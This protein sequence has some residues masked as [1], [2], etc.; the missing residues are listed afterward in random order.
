MHDTDNEREREYTNTK[1]DAGIPVSIKC[2]WE[3]W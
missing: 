2:A 1:L 3:L